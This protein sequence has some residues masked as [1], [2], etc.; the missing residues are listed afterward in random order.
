M[1][2]PDERTRAVYYAQV[3]LR[4]LLDPAKTPRVSKEVR[5]QARS[6]L[7]HFPNL[8]ELN[9]VAR[10]EE[11]YGGLQVFAPIDDKEE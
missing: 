7:K 3:F 4:S 9:I 8:H 11:R 10:M 6:I 1:T 2:L 5:R